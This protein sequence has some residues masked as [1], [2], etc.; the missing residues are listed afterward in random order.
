MGVSGC[1]EE[2]G[3]GGKGGWWGERE[4]RGEIAVFFVEIK[5]GCGRG[6]EYGCGV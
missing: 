3:G 5:C 6:C 2:G 1:G 4:V